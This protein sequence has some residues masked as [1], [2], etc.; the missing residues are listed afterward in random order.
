[1]RRIV[2]EPA[3]AIN[4]REHVERFSDRKIAIVTRPDCK[5]WRAGI[6]DVSDSPARQ[7]TPTWRP[8]EEVPPSIG[9]FTPC[10]VGD[11]VGGEPENF[12]MQPSGALRTRR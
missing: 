4:D 9:A 2:C 5:T 11:V 7:D 10:R 8:G 1:M 12:E 6:Y 3:I